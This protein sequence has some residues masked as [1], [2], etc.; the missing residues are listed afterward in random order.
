MVFVL[1]RLWSYRKETARRFLS[2]SSPP[3]RHSLQ[4]W[5]R[6]W[7]TRFWTSHHSVQNDVKLFLM[8]VW[9]CWLCGIWKIQTAVCLPRRHRQTKKNC[10]SASV[11]YCSRRRQVCFFFFYGS[12]SATTMTRFILHLYQRDYD[13]LIAA[14][15]SSIFHLYQRDPNLL[16]AVLAC[17]IF[18]HFT[19]VILAF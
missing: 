4:C 19:D 7:A 14:L 2:N 8:G 12:W 5:A 15:T 17:S 16:I 6:I 10:V 3:S 11:R 13:L 1:T 9:G 18:W